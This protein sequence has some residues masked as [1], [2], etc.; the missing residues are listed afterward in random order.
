MADIS[1][2]PQGGRGFDH[3]SI[4]AGS[5]RLKRRRWAELRLKA[6]GIAAIGIAGFALVALLSSVVAQASRAMT[7]HYITA[8]VTLDPEALGISADAT[9]NEILRADFDGLT[10]QVM[11][12]AFPE[13]SG[14]TERR[15][16]G[17]LISGG[18]PFELADKITA[19]PGLLGETITYD[20]L[21]SDVTD[22]YLKDEYGTLNQ[23]PVSGSLSVQESDDGDLILTSTAEDF[24]GALTQVKARLFTDAEDL[25]VKAARQTN[26]VAVYT[27]RAAAAETEEDRTEQLEK[28]E[29]ARAN[30]QELLDEAAAIEARAR[31]AGGT[32]EV[33]DEN[34]SLLV[35]AGGG[36]IRL[37]E[38]SLTQARGEVMTRTA[39]PIEAS[40]DWGFYTT[41]QPESSRKVTD[42]QIVWIET[43]KD[44][45]QIKETFN[46]RF[47]TSAD[48]RAPELAGIRGALVGSLLTMAVTFGLAFPIGVLG[49]IYLEEFAPKN[50]FT[51]FLEVNINNLAAVPSIVFGLLGLA[52]F[53]NVFGVPRS[54]P[55]AGGIVLAL[56]TLPTIIIAAR[57]AIQAVPP[58]IRE[59]ALGVGASNVQASFHHVLPLA[60]PGILTGT[61]IGMAQALG[62][63]APLI[64]IGMVAFIV[65]VPTGITD[66]ATVLPVQVYRWS[67]FPERAFEARTAAAIC[68]LLLFLV[69][70]NLLAIVLRRRF[71]RRW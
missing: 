27:E 48:S 63:T 15:A 67:D 47:F 39:L 46:W 10:T 3:G 9:G 17:N 20:F 53:L 2:N 51:N 70:M 25:R 50:R 45:G 60:M 16:L 11:R 66:S 34:I 33:D 52:V 7:E 62:E 59:A 18:A 44:R 54:A 35:K 22:L 56:M 12:D 19:E 68:V 24:S 38:V 37:T 57:A 36:W 5:S 21:A 29:K 69:L 64:M 6:Y 1:T 41:S 65:D 42:H 55:L 32:E 13:A 26:A 4:T 23:E 40:T 28:A 43:L 31:A 49:A 8:E 14:R 61:I 30:E 71:E 58:S